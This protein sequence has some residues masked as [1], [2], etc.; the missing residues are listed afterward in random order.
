LLSEDDLEPQSRPGNVV[1]VLVMGL[2][3]VEHV[4][5]EFDIELGGC[6]RNPGE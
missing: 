5:L 4:S 1:R 2:L 6:P 3:E